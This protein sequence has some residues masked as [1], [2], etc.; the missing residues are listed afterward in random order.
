VF[1]G[2]TIIS[3]KGNQVGMTDEIE[4]PLEVTVQVDPGVCRLP[5]TIIAR[6]DGNIVEF[7]V[8]HSECPQ[9]RN[10]SRVLKRMEVWD[11]M[12][13]PFSDNTVYQICGEVLKHSSCPV[14]VAMI[15]AAEAATEMALKKPVTIT[16][17]D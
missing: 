12:R 6:T 8:V 3:Q 17:L 7:E 1:Q 5:S 14:P 16:F 10:L 4:L 2:D 13:M 15:K 11:I 9:V